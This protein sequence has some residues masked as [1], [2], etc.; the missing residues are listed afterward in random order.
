MVLTQVFAVLEL[1][2]LSQRALKPLRSQDQYTYSVWLQLQSEYLS[3]A[4]PDSGYC[5][6]CRL[7]IVAREIH[8]D[9]MGLM[10]HLLA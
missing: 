2:W 5:L 1:V 10:A 8:V 7:R 4:S 6:I 9:Q 3:H